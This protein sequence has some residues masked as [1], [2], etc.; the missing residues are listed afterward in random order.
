MINN[1]A[2]SETSHNLNETKIL[3][4]N[5][6]DDVL[7]VQALQARVFTMQATISDLEHQEQQSSVSLTD[8]QSSC[9][10]KTAQLLALEN[11]NGQQ[12]S[13]IE[14]MTES[15]AQGQDREAELQATR[16]QVNQQAKEIL[17]LKET[18]CDRE[19]QYQIELEVFAESKRDG[20]AERQTLEVRQLP[21]WECSRVS[22]LKQPSESSH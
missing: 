2:T 7:R 16:R 9:D 8:M 22:S 13:Q 3:I 1:L 10:E 15:L 14:C 20:E 4:Q 18:V 17:D 5:L 12:R 19:A 6:R 21:P 11:L